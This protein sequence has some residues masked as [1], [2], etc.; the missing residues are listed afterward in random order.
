MISTD[1]E[2]RVFSLQQLSLNWKYTN[3]YAKDIR[4]NFYR[5]RSLSFPFHPFS[6]I[7]LPSFPLSPFSAQAQ[8][9]ATGIGETL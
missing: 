1:A 7:P 5:S 2:R 8:N 4:R 6:F 9:L 3:F